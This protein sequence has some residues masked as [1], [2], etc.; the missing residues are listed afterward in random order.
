MATTQCAETRDFTGGQQV[1]LVGLAGRADL[2]GSAG[3]LIGWDSGA[4]RWKVNISEG[5]SAG[6]KLNVRPV[7]LQPCS[8]SS[9]RRAVPKKAGVQVKRSILKSKMLSRIRGHG[10]KKH[11]MS[12]GDIVPEEGMEPGQGLAQEKFALITSLQARK[13]LNGSAAELLDFD[14]ER[15]R[16]SI[17]ILSAAEDEP[18]WV[19]PVNLILGKQASSNK[20]VPLLP[21]RANARRVSDKSK[22]LKAKRIP[23]KPKRAT[24]SYMLFCNKIRDEVTWKYRVEHGTVDL[25][26]IAKIFSEQWAD[27][28]EKERGKYQ[29]MSAKRQEVRQQ[30]MQAY[31]E[32]ADPL[33][34]LRKR[35]D[36]LIPKRAASPYFLFLADKAQRDKAR[37]DMKRQRSKLGINTML[38]EMWK[39]LGADQKNLYQEKFKN[40]KVEYDTKLK[41]WQQRPEFAELNKLEVEQRETQKAEKKEQQGSEEVAIDAILRRPDFGSGMGLAVN[42][43][44]VICELKVRTDLNGN[45]VQL[46]EFDKE[47][48]RWNFKL[49]ADKKAEMMSLKP[50]NFRLTRPEASAKKAEVADKKAE[51]AAEKEAHKAAKE[52]QEAEK[53]AEAAAERES[54]KAA[55]QAQEA[56]KSAKTVAERE[57][58]KTAKKAQE[59]GKLAEAAAEREA[60]TAGKVAARETKKAEKEA[61]KAEREAQKAE[62][63]AA[64]AGSKAAVSAGNLLIRPSPCESP[65]AIELQEGEDLD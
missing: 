47:R 2:N 9:S 65:P 37:Q 42:R 50:E 41:I 46:I 48:E 26:E 36:H 4:G 8:A 44:A 10:A 33:A 24:T 13:D 57:A 62:K 3:T 58:Q 12:S 30:K 59:A 27:L 25:G 61:Q 51:A 7:N 11:G 55:K 63:V 49:T 45:V 40:D 22:A 38:T 54:Q 15:G 5:S 31:M 23:K 53:K 52:A 14:D 29:R 39:V 60:R 17:K 56:E 64:R 32:V 20:V 34:A 35:Y 21:Q 16:W 43:L 6:E 1:I 28:S 19:K 18:M